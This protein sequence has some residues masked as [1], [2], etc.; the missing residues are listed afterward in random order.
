MLHGNLR[1][2]RGTSATAR[3]RICLRTP[4]SL[5]VDCQDRIQSGEGHLQLKY[6]RLKQKLAAE[7]SLVQIIRSHRLFS[8]KIAVITSPTGAAVRDFLQILRRREFAGGL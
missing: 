2:A 6:E 3:R 1:T 7:D 4:W 8:A 5:P